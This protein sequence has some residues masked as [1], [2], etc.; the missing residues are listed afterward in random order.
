MLADVTARLWGLAVGAAFVVVLTAGVAT[1]QNAN[2]FVSAEYSA[3]FRHMAGAQVIEVRVIDSDIADTDEPKG[4]PDVAVN[5]KALRMAQTVDGTW[6]G[7]FASLVH[8]QIADET[9]A[10]AAVSGVGLDF[11]TFCSNQSAAAVGVSVTDA[12]G[13]ALPDASG[14]TQGTTSPLTD[15]TS[16]V[17][18]SV[19]NV[20]R[21]APSL[22]PGGVGGVL[23]GQIDV[24]PDAWPFIQLYM[25][26]PVSSVVV[27]YNKGSGAQI[28]T[29]DFDVASASV[30]VDE[31]VYG[32]EAD[33]G[34][35]VD[36]VALDIDP[37]DADSW[38]FDTVTGAVHYQVFDA[39]GS[40]R[41]DARNGGTIDVSASLDD[42]MF[43]A[44]KGIVVSAGALLTLQDNADSRLETK[45]PEDIA[46]VLTEGA[47]AGVVGAL[48]AGTQPLTLTQGATTSFTSVDESGVSNL[49]TTRRAATAIATVTYAGET[50]DIVVN[51]CTG[52]DDGAQCDNGTYCDGVDRCVSE[53]CEAAD[54]MD[55]DDGV[56]CTVDSCN[57]PDDRCEHTARDAR[58]DDDDV[59]TVDRCDPRDGCFHESEAFCESDAGASD[60][61][62]GEPSDARDAGRRGADA[63]AV[64]DAGR[65]RDGGPVG[66]ARGTDASASLDAGLAADAG[67]EAGAGGCS[68]RVTGA[69]GYH[70]GVLALI[71][72]VVLIGWRRRARQGAR[73]VR[74]QG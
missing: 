10:A 32:R 11:G 3:S 29:V 8:A 15:C 62:A 72:A 42:L 23:P 26:A 30:A 44:G 43:G 25:L 60:T 34:V 17:T 45:A 33:V 56:A 57:E 37:T 20:V 9:V 1:A 73:K 47:A 13:V 2:L 59:C 54:A 55:C 66:S 46:S 52:Q 28:T 71:A 63:S 50:V 58:C 31:A 24:D 41:G 38:T 51:P 7:Y 39:T 67:D 4:E 64:R 6:V 35:T 65:E 61:D 18:P 16:A 68:C 27:Q 14:G 22:N 21:N 36:N 70:R 40:A 12:H 48:G 74:E 5:G 53:V 19:M 69:R 49:R